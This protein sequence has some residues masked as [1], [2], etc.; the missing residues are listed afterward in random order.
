[1]EN[2]SLHKLVIVKG[3]YFS[4]VEIPSAAMTSMTQGNGYKVVV[5][6]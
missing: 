3:G 4:P 5:L 6:A 1:M 2:A